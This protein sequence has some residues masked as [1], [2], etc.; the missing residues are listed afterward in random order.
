MSIWHDTVTIEAA[1]ARGENTLFSHLGMNVIEVGDDYLSATMPVDE[2]TKQPI[3][4]LNGGA[5][6]A[7]AESLASLAANLAVDREKRYCVG[8]EINGNHIK[9]ARGGEVTATARPYH[10]GRSTQVWEIRIV[11]GENLICISR[12]TLAVIERT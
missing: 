7:L 3:G 5:S 10:L 11:Q 9:S 8:V 1:N 4:L 12:M 2:R 6:L